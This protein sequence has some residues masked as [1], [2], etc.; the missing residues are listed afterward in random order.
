M[1]NSAR[2]ING[3]SD[4][5][6]S[7]PLQPGTV[8]SLQ[9][10]KIVAGGLAL[11]RSEGHVILFPDGIPGETVL[12][13]VLSRRKGVYQGQIQKVASPAPDRIVPVCPL[14]GQCGGCHFQHIT[15]AEQLRQKGLIVEDALKR[16]GKFSDLVVPALIPSS[17][18]FG[19]RQALRLGVRQ[20]RTGL[21]MGFFQRESNRLVAVEDCYLVGDAFR[22]LLQQVSRQVAD[23]P[24]RAGWLPEIEIRHST[25][26]QGF[27]V[28][29]QGNGARP[30]ESERLVERCFGLSHIIG[31]V[32]HSKTQDTSENPQDP[33]SRKTE[34]PIIRGEDH[35]WESFLG[36]RVK[37][38]Y[39]SFMQANWQLFQMLGET[40][41]KWV[42]QKTG[43]RILELYAGTCPIGMAL[44]RQ[45]DSVRCIEVNQEAVRNARESMR[46]NGVTGC[47]V[48][49]TF[50]E[51]FLGRLT[52]GEYDVIVLD[53]PRTG[54]S[55]KVLAQLCQL[56]IPRVIYLSCDPP[57]LARDMKALHQG[58]YHVRRIQPFDMF[59]QTAHVET[60]VELTR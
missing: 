18:S 46:T 4:S 32:Y 33:R 30:S 49:P 12:V 27:L 2:N 39:R 19:Y 31:C 21:Q 6:T 25:L 37:I 48:T 29:F 10:E 47:R 59:P 44:A 41:V 53:P 23:I 42:G 9:V 58:G 38:G 14:V 50:S 5:P 16:I 26:Q 22:K 34:P 45:G 55:Q 8:V 13:K 3:I 24:A 1:L 40:I 20:G 15:Y 28:V 60:L 52:S 43:S 17:Q 7:S 56:R 35:I 51:S 57:T 54:L 11:S 36:M